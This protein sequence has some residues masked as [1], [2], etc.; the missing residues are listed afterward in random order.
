MLHMH[1][2]T[3]CVCVTAAQ[4]KDKK[5]AEERERYAAHVRQGATGAGD[6]DEGAKQAAARREALH[7]AEL[8]KQ[9]RENE[10][11]QG[12]CCCCCCTTVRLLH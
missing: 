9:I 7:R 4:L 11:V 8:M 3:L 10:K 5:A 12:C 6:V 1:R 2:L